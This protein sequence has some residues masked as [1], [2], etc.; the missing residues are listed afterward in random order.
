MSLLRAQRFAGQGL[1]SPQGE[2]GQALLIDRVALARLLGRSLAWWDKNRARLYALGFPQPVPGMGKRW[3]PVA[4]ENWLAQQ[5]GELSTP[6]GDAGREA[7]KQR[8]Q[9]L[10]A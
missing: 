10:A 7:R 3:D 4:I 6:Q 1:R 9:N 5:R 2:A 8:A